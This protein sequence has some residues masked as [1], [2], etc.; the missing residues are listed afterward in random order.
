MRASRAFTC[1]ALLLVILLIAACNSF[2]VRP[3]ERQELSRTVELE[4]AERVEVSIRPGVQELALTGGAQSLFTGDFIYNLDQ[5]E[6]IIDYRVNNGVGRLDVA[7]TGGTFGRLPIGNVVSMWNLRLNSEVP[8]ALEMA[9]G[10]GDSQID[11]SDVNLTDFDLQSGAGVVN[12]DLG[13]QDLDRVRV[14]A[15]LGDTNLNLDGGRVEELEFEAGA[16]S[17]AI[18]LV[19]N[20]EANME[21]EIDGGLGDL[22][23]IV[24]ASTGV[25]IEVNT[26]LGDVDVDGFQADGNAYTNAAYGESEVTLDIHIDQGAGSVR[27]QTAD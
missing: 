3:G 25:R 26:G 13:V 27:I 17:V 21:V 18:N 10:L 23:L 1:I 22:E 9:L 16:G 7:V 4:D 15:G 20:W 12:V 8:I 24:P 19:G 11:L 6:P 2:W 5:L 14:R